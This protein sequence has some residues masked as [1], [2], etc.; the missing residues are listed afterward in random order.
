MR[1]SLVHLWSV[2]FVL[3]NFQWRVY[4]SILFN[5]DFKNGSRGWAQDIRYE[6]TKDAQNAS[7]IMMSPYSTITKN[8][9]TVGYGS[10]HVS[11]H[12]AAT[13]LEKEDKCNFEYSYDKGFTYVL[14]QSQTSK[15]NK[16]GFF[17]SNF[18]LPTIA[19]NN[20]NF[21]IRYRASGRN[22][23]DAYCIAGETTVLGT[24]KNFAAAPVVDISRT[25]YDNLVGSG[26]V[27]RK[28]LTVEELFSDQIIPGP[29]DLSA[30]TIPKEASNPTNYFQGPLGMSFHLPLKPIALN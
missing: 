6:S 26:D 14:L 28:K 17:T 1:F 5:D 30:Y 22:T 24:P 2:C 10:I 21:M 11:I 18:S 4:S 13:G 25:V 29:I 7:F 3:I 16:K 12:L 23:H 9:S 20:K 15:E 27:D 19:G 8:I